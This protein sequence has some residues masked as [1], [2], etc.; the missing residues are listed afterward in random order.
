MRRAL[1]AV[2]AL[3]L[4]APAE[5]EAAV[6]ATTAAASISAAVRPSSP[7]FGDTFAYVIRVTTP[8]ASADAARIVSDV[9]PFTRLAPAHVTRAVSNGVATI[10]VTETVACLA[11]GCLPPKAGASVTLPAARVTANGA[12]VTAEPVAVRVGSRVTAAE[13]KARNP[14]FSRPTSL[15]APTTSFDPALAAVGL[16]ALGVALVVVGLI[17]LLAP[18]RRRDGARAAEVLDPVERA[19]RLLRESAGRDAPDRRRAAALASRVAEEQRLANDAATVAWSRP[20]PGPPDATT[21]A[22]RLEQAAG[23]SA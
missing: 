18:L 16:A 17:V 14:A 12:A 11:V 6:P 20:E 13:V 10:T 5:T 9:A 22:D 4:L 3:A 19:A 23:R 1:T 7:L 15:P 8:E 2:A 21:L